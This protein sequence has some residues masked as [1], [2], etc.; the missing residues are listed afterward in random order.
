MGGYALGVCDLAE[1]VAVRAV[2]RSDDEDEIDEL[3]ELF[4]GE[5]AVGRGVAQVVA[6]DHV[7]EA[8]LDLV[9]DLQ[10]IVDGEGRLGE[11]GDGRVVVPFRQVDAIALVNE[12]HGPVA[13][14]APDLLVAP[15]PDDDELSPLAVVPL[16]LVVDLRHEGTG[17]VED[18]EVSVLRALEVLRRRAV[19]REDDDGVGR[20]LVNLL[21]GLRALG[22]EGIHDVRVVDDLVLHVDRRAESLKRD[23]DH[24]DG[25]DHAGAKAPRRAEVDVHA[26]PPS[27]VGQLY[28]R[29]GSASGIGAREGCILHAS[30]S[31][32]TGNEDR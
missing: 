17:G 12:E 5:L 29:A 14:G 13:H 1:A 2:G 16:G 22:F 19:G 9:D 28:H 7:V 3:A 21:D 24:V 23:L 27:E 6:H 26:A 4:D 25:H 11:D 18:V 10:G 32:G 20:Y 8:V 31:E 15:V 30:K